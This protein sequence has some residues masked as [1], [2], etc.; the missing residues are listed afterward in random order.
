MKITFD[1]NKVPSFRI[2]I[3]AT[4]KLLNKKF[5]FEG[6]I[7]IRSGSDSHS[8]WTTLPLSEAEVERILNNT[9]KITKSKRKEEVK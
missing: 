7:S 2:E 4:K 3:N 1:L 5:S 6:S 8:Y 9:L